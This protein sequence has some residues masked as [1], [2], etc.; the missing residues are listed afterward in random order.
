MTTDMKE[1]CRDCG[2]EFTI[3]SGEQKFYQDHHWEFPK[4]CKACRDKR[5]AMKKKKDNR[6]E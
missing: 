6:E 2:E 4:R 3:T 1:I 5:K